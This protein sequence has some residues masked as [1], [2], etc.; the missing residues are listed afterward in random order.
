MTRKHYV[1][2][3]EIIA[4]NE[5][6]H[7]TGGHNAIIAMANSMADYFKQDNPKFQPERF[8]TACG[9]E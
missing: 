2:I 1:A 8:L 3:A 6:S 5:F 4:N 7:T 9:I